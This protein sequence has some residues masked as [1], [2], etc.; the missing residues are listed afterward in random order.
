MGRK[1]FR[2]RPGPVRDSAPWFLRSRVFPTR[3]LISCAVL[4]IDGC[5]FHKVFHFWHKAALKFMASRASLRPTLCSVS[6]C[7]LL[8]QSL[9][10]NMVWWQC[11]NETKEM[12]G[13]WFWVEKINSQSCVSFLFY[14]RGRH[15]R[16]VR[17]AIGKPFLV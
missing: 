14:T 4:D 11:G 3:I 6:G 13:N 10:S 12:S 7:E 15:F 1:S 17:Q 16:G 8:A 9:A 5:P 2:P